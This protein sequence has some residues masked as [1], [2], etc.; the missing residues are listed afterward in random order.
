MKDP[1]GTE[2]PRSHGKKHKDKSQ[3]TVDGGNWQETLEITHL[4]TFVVVHGEP[5]DMNL[6]IKRIS[7]SR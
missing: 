7:R 1:Y 4:S 2:K 6:G 3:F 5:V